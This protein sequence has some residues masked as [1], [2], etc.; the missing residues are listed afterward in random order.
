[1]KYIP[2]KFF[3]LLLLL[4]SSLSAQI[5]E[6]VVVDKILAKVDN[7][8]VLKSEMEVAYLQYLSSGEV[9]AGDAKCRVLE[10]LIINKLLLAKAEIDSV[11]VSEEMVEGNLDQRMQAFISQF[12][13]ESKLEEFYGKS[14]DEFKDEFRDQVKEQLLIQRMDD[15]VASN[16]EATPKEVRKFF[17]QIP[18][19]SL[20]FFSTE[21]EIGVLIR[22]I[23]QGEGSRKQ[24][25]IKL[26]EI[27]EEITNGT[28]FREMAKV[29][30]T[31][32][33]NKERGG[34]LGYWK[35]SDL[36]PDYVAAALKLDS[37]EVSQ[38]VKTQFGFHLIQMVG[39]RGNEF[40]SR[41]ILLKPEFSNLDITVTA[42]LLD[43]IKG[44]IAMDS[45]SFEQAA[46][47][48]S[49]DPYTKSNGG[50]LVD[51]NTGASKIPL[52]RL[53][54][55][56]YFSID[57]M[58]AGQIS[59]PILF[60][61]PNGQNAMRL[62][63]YKS[64]SPPHQAN[65]KDDYQKIYQA[66]VEEKRFQKKKEWFENTKNEVFIDIDDDFQNCKILQ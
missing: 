44:L 39:R 46:I 7:Y 16:L 47:K 63:Y 32:Y 42:E 26:N 45:M 28:D 60:K 55:D 14:V 1:L 10:S 48:F 34:E 12:G 27:R 33:G 66:T 30:S 11:T 62:I 22:K 29:H 51:Q 18:E 38:V 25:V 17:S 58:E 41:H 49:E 2:I 52:E 64:K 40:N 6:S 50:L 3:I 56:M 20:P 54:P 59:S 31:D 23:E 61:Q 4:S 57:T 43:S 36:D 8:I 13:S 19:D 15:Q 5:T 65:L 37:G 21:V 9:L 53:D 24:I 35:K